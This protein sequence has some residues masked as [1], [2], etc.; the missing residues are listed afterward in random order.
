VI[1]KSIDIF[2]FALVVMTLAVLTFKGIQLYLGAR[3]LRRP[4]PADLAKAAHWATEPRSLADRKEIVAVELERLEAGM[5][6]V[7]TI[8]AT[9]PFVGLMGTVLHIMEALSRIGGASLDIGLISGPIATALNS[10]LVGLAAAVP[11]AIAYNLYSRR[12]QVMDNAA[13]RIFERESSEKS[14]VQA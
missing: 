5:A 10:T 7:G 11:A 3:W 6:V 9:A 14:E 12:I 4:V 13:R 8:A 1:A 2:L